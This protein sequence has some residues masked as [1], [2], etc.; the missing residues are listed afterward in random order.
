MDKKV[1]QDL[2]QKG[3]KIYQTPQELS[4]DPRNVGLAVF[5]K[6]ENNGKMAFFDAGLPVKLDDEAFVGSRGDIYKIFSITQPDYTD[7]EETGL[8][9]QEVVVVRLT[10]YH[11]LDLNPNWAINNPAAKMARA[12]YVPDEGYGI[13]SDCDSVRPLNEMEQYLDEEEG[14]R[15]AYNLCS[16]HAERKN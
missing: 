2:V 3:V 15:K 11:P 1:L 5:I 7:R 9:V 8:G 10:N 16:L 13:C 12:A 4:Y 6:N 14:Y